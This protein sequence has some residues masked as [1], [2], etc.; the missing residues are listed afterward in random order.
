MSRGE[1]RLLG[2][3]GAAWV[4][5]VLHFFGVVPLAGALA[6]SL[7]L[8]YGVAACL[9]W[10]FGNVFVLR[11]RRAAAEVGPLLVLYLFGPL[12]AVYL[13]WALASPARQQAA[14]LAALWAFG[15]YGVFFLV[16]VLFPPP[17]RPGR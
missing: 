13:L 1:R 4:V 7:Y 14:P 15:V 5:A 12:A 2:F 8:Y 3:F 9:G 17:V 10:L 6:L 16:P 11:R